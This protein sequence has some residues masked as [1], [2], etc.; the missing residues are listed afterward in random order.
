MKEKQLDKE[1]GCSLIEVKGEV[2]EFVSGG[3][4]HPQ[5]KEIYSVLNELKLMLQ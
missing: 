4:V 1:P 2:H 3:R 5:A